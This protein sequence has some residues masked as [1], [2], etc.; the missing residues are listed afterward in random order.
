MTLT[1]AQLKIATDAFILTQLSETELKFKAEIDEVRAKKNAADDYLAKLQSLCPHPLIMRDHK[2]SS[3]IGGYDRGSDSYW[4]D[5]KCTM[6]DKR[7]QTNQRWAQVGGKQGHP[8]D[9]AAKE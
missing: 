9:I 4:T 8:N 7:W 6:C 5:H 1:A 3:S 2:N